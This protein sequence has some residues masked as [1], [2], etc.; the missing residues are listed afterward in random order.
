[1]SKEPVVALFDEAYPPG[2]L[3]VRTD[4]GGLVFRM[5]LVNLPAGRMDEVMQDLTHLLVS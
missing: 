2:V 1:M 5:P 4:W 3:P